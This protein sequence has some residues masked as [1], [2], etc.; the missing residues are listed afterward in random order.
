MCMHLL[1]VR[2]HDRGTIL[3][4]L[5]HVQRSTDFPDDDVRLTARTRMR[6]RSIAS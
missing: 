3:R 4:M 5:K 2:G 1:L 6:M